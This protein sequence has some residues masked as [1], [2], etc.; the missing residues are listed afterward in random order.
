MTFSHQ[1]DAQT[2]LFIFSVKSSDSRRGADERASVM[3]CE[4]QKDM[5]V[6]KCSVFFTHAERGIFEMDGKGLG[7]LR[8]H[9][10]QRGRQTERGGKRRRGRGASRL[11]V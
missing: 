11:S 8:G 6:P 7:L 2:F 5:L 4:K 1:I 10:R 3:S 9:K